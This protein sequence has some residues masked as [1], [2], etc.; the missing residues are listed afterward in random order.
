MASQNEKQPLF[1]CLAAVQRVFEAFGNCGVIIGGVA[2]G[3]MAKPRAT[4]DVDA[5]ILLDLDELP[6][7]LAVA[8]AHGLQPRISDPADFARRSRI[9]LLRHEPTG[10][11]VDISLGVLPFEKEVIDRAVIRKA[12]K[13][14]VSLAS[15]EDLII[16]KAVAHRPVDLFDIQMIV[17]ANPEL[18]KARI[19]SWVRQF[20]EALDMPELW[21]DIAGF[22]E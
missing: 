19:E 17:A 12:G 20:A 7:L 11:H 8:R 4:I 22:F 13:V 14:S 15:P 10:I 2:V 6:E 5:M 9:V 21:D 16:L 18:D 3:L 1:D